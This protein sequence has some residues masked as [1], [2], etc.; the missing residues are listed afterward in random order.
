[1]WR[2]AGRQERQRHFAEHEKSAHASDA[3]KRLRSEEG[4]YWYRQRKW[5]AEPRSGGSSTYW[6]SGASVCGATRK[7]KRVAIGLRGVKS[8]ENRG[9]DH[10]LTTTGKGRK[11]ALRGR[12]KIIPPFLV[13]LHA[14]SST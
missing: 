5:L 3:R 6:A 1:M 9:P 10:L 13:A 8:E 2:W 11:T 14:E 7:F 12:R 4:R